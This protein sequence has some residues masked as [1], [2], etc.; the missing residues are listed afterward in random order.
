[1]AEWR[2]HLAV[3]VP[4]GAHRQAYDR[5][6]AHMLDTNFFPNS[7]HMHIKMRIKKWLSLYS[8]YLI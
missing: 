2:L 5:C 6:T 8:L 4:G 3:A 1:M 7:A